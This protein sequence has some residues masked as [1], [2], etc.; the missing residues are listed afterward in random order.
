MD[1]V[2]RSALSNSDGTVTEIDFIR[3]Q[4]KA[5]PS[6]KTPSEAVPVARVSAYTMAS[7]VSGS[8]AS[9]YQ[10]G[11]GYIVFRD[12]ERDIPRRFLCRSSRC[13]SS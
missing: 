1:S 10:L 5:K 7:S 8:M 9:S 13:L 2:R 12:A 11:S 6:F 4:N 3:C